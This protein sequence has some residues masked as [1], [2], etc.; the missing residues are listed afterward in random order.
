M[1][2]HLFARSFCLLV[3]LFFVQNKASCWEVR[4]LPVSLSMDVQVSAPPVLVLS[5]PYRALLGGATRSTH[6]HTPNSASMFFSSGTAHPLPQS[7]SRGLHPPFLISTQHSPTVNKENV[8]FL[9]GS[10]LADRVQPS[11]HAS[12]LQTP[13]DNLFLEENM[14]Q[15]SDIA[16]KTALLTETDL[17]QSTGH[18][19]PETYWFLNRERAL[20]RWA[21]T[22]SGA[23]QLG[24]WSSN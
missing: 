23:Q 20:G 6:A 11:R 15:C 16:V 17:F 22:I 18:A 12:L 8:K 21:L 5:L 24:F 2:T 7:L 10:L 1:G 14:M 13:K 4:A 3:A 19:R 9:V